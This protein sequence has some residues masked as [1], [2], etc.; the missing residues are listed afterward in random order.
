LT[1]NL[2]LAVSG[3]ALGLAL[4]AIAVRIL[5]VSAPAGIPRMEKLSIEPAVLC[6]TGGL[7]LLAGFLSGMLP[8]FG[9]SRTDLNEALKRDIG[10]GSD[11]THKRWGRSLVV[12]QIALAM[13]LLSSATLLI[14]SYWKLAHVET[15]LD[16]KQVF[17][18]DV[19]WPA[20]SDGNSVD[21]AFV[22]RAAPEILARIR[23]LP[24]VESVAFVKGLPF[25]FAPDGG[26]EIAGRALPA[27]PHLAPDAD[28]RLVTSE[29]FKLL[30]IRVL[31]GR[32]FTPEDARSSAQVAIVNQSFAKEFFRDGDPL[33]Q[34]IRFFGFDRKPQFLTIIG[35][36]PDVRASFNQ[37]PRSEVYAEYLQ[38]AD[39]RMDADLV[40]RGPAT[41][42]P[43]IDQIVTSVNRFTAVDF[44]SM[45]HVISSTVSR[46]RF[47]TTLLGVFAATAL[48]LAVVGIYG[49]FSYIVTTRT[50]DLGLRMAL[51]ASRG[52]ILQMILSE[53]G[54]LVAVG[55]SLGVLGSFLAARTL[56]SLLYQ[57]KATDPSTLVVAVACF[58]GAALI[59][60]YLPARHATRIDPLQALRTE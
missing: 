3:G 21:G 17:L 48:L 8:S 18:T 19:T 59:A 49:L 24:G 1:E 41:L 12:G 15:G 26:F 56:Q 38:H 14:K 46:E 37:P 32:A 27:D 30:R 23:E 22:K 53:A 39:S 55:V 60:A 57:I 31:R 4:A 29:Y 50:S 58:A 11:Q 36:V 2:L 51:G 42:Q 28:Y 16:T 5:R 40:V 47:E 45:D 7:A 34:R 20:A 6:F 44:E 43:K 35:V 25:D 10:K 13:L 54:I 9:S 33:G 52:S